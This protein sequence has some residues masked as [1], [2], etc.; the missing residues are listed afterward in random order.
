MPTPSPI[1]EPSSADPDARP[2]PRSLGGRLLDA[3]LGAV[4]HGALALAGAVIDRAEKADR[5]R[6]R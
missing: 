3:C 6:R 1:D 4:L 5:S 2:T